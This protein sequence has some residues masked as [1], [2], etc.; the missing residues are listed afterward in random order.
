MA[1]HPA[2]ERVVER[3][4]ADVIGG[5]ADTAK[6]VVSAL[7]QVATDSSAP[8]TT[9]LMSELETAIDRILSVLPSLAPP[10]NA[11]HVIMARAESLMEEGGTVRELKQ[12]LQEEAQAFLKRAEDALERVAQ[13]GAEIIKDG[14]TIFTYSMSSTVWRVLRRAKAHGKNIEVVVT[15]SRPANEGLWTVEE[16]EKA[17]IP[18]SV[19]ID[20]CVGVL[21]PTCSLVMVGADAISAT[22]HALCK[23]GTYPTALVAREH[24][25]PFY[26]AADT[27]KFDT[28]TL[29]GLPFR[30]DPLTREQVLSGKTYEKT[31]VVGEHFDVTPPEL[32]TAII[33]ERGLIHPA[34]CFTVM[35]RMGVSKRVS[36]RLPAWA[37]REF[38]REG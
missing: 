38:G 18:V 35:E 7:A 4:R 14:D 5:A 3:I 34:S 26:I 20:A 19:S 16:M 17:D 32:V 25:I 23:V 6:E 10:V 1:E 12:A 33:T 21:V 37:R 22:G 24:R 28:T 30:V 11:L 2:L 29:L 9:A 8:S 36:A 31:R 13:Y 27:L 15:E